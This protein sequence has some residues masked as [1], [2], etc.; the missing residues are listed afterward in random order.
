M[1]AT[2]AVILREI[3]GTKPVLSRVTAVCRWLNCEPAWELSAQ[4]Q[5]GTDASLKLFELFLRVHKNTR[6][7]TVHLGSILWLSEKLSRNQLLELEHEIGKLY[8][9]KISSLRNEN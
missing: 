6:L 2:V 3:K 7:A 5:L 1:D 4:Q 9:Q 8:S